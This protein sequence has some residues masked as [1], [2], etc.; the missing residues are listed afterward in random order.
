MIF[1]VALKQEVMD[2]SN[3]CTYLNAS[4]EVMEETEDSLD[5]SLS[6]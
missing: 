2:S 6:N 5:S 4:A 3:D 1:Q